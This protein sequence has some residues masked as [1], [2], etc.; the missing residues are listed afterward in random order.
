[1]LRA[2]GVPRPVGQND[3]LVV[4]T[5]TRSQVNTT[6]GAIE[7]VSL[8]GRVDGLAFLSETEACDGTSVPIHATLSKTLVETLTTGVYSAV[9]E[10]ADKTTH[11]ASLPD[12]A[13]RWRHFVFGAD[14]HVSDAVAVRRRRPSSA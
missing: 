14:Y 2:C 4:C 10:G 7:S 9:I 1:M 3:D 13:R 12:G 11:L 6:S 8:T 5:P